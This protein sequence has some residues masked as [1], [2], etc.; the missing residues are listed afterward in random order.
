PSGTFVGDWSHA[1]G[2]W[3]ATLRADP[4]LP[5]EIYHVKAVVSG[6]TWS[7]TF[8]LRFVIRPSVSVR[9]F[10]YTAGKSSKIEATLLVPGT[11]NARF[12]T[13]GDS[14]LSPEELDL[15]TEE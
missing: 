13:E 10:P 9:T 14:T 7:K 15:S 2:K 11:V 3:S 6:E 4:A 12:S 1:D 5:A 8:P